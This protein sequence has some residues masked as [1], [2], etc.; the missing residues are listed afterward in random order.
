[1]QIPVYLFYCVCSPR[2]IHNFNSGLGIEDSCVLSNPSEPNSIIDVSAKLQAT[3]L[4][5]WFAMFL[6][7]RVKASKIYEIGLFWQKEILSGLFKGSKCEI[8]KY[9]FIILQRTNTNYML[10]I[11]NR[12][13]W[14]LYLK[15]DLVENILRPSLKVIQAVKIEASSEFSM[16]HAMKQ[17]LG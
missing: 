13:A 10:L 3:L 7:L 14:F 4:C 2:K 12:L 6:T 1:M 17:T 5:P 8:F 9:N 11:I 15:G 16:N